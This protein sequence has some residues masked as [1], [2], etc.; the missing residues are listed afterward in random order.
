M[1]HISTIMS[2]SLEA[3]TCPGSETGMSAKFSS[4]ISAIRFA[5]SLAIAEALSLSPSLSCVRKSALICSCSRILLSR[6]AAWSPM[7]AVLSSILVATVADILSSICSLRVSREARTV[8][9]W[10]T[11]CDEVFI[12]LLTF[13][14]SFNFLSAPSLSF[15]LRSS[16]ASSLKDVTLACCRAIS[17][18]LSAIPLV[19][20][21]ISFLTVSSASFVFLSSLPSFVFLLNI[22]FF[23]YLSLRAIN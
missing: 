16:L 11:T 4:S 20:F 18:S 19:I 13:C 7:A 15:F 22:F 1:A 9:S 17:A 21:S 8:E 14:I 12:W 6:S 23:K 3:A 2:R 10:F 5:R